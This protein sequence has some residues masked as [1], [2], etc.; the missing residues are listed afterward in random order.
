MTTNLTPAT[1]VLPDT[2]TDT[3]PERIWLQ[4]D[5]SGDPDN[6]TMQFPDSEVTWCRGSCGGVEV[7]YVRS[8][9][10]RNQP[11]KEVMSVS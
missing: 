8:D 9:L 10:A 1:V 5:T 7:E 11:R 4:I 2:L 3:A 6:R